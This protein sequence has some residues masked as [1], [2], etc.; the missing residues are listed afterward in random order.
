MSSIL[1][2]HAP[3]ITIRLST[4]KTVLLTFEELTELLSMAPASRGYTAAPLYPPVTPTAPRPYEPT[5]TC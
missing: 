5:I 2:P 4:G 1:P 3:E